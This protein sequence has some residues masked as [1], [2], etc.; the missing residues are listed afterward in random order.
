VHVV[1][2]QDPRWQGEER[3][4]VRP[5]IRVAAEEDGGEKEPPRGTG[6]AR[7]VARDRALF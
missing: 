1:I 3:A 6:E 2:S 7:V 5:P 4:R